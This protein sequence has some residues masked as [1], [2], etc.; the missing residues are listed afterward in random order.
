MILSSN[1]Y[2][3]VIFVLFLRLLE[4]ADPVLHGLFLAGG[5]GQVLLQLLQLA[6]RLHCRLPAKQHKARGK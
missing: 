1:H 3:L 5:L 4:L 6:V 2:L